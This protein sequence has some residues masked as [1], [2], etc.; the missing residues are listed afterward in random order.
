[1]LSCSDNLVKSALQKSMQNVIVFVFK[2]IFHMTRWMYL[3][4][5]Q[6]LGGHAPKC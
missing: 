6:H 1:M 4:R 2:K 5:D 3:C